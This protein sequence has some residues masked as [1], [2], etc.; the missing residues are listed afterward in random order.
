M[1]DKRDGMMDKK[2]EMM[3][4]RDTMGGEHGE[5]EHKREME[6]DGAMDEHS[7]SM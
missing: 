5:M 3:E 1:M 6:K 7:D 2:D 4:N